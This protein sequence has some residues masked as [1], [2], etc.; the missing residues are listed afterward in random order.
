MLGG[1]RDEFRDGVR[2]G[3]GRVGSSGLSGTEDRNG[4]K[5]SVRVQYYAMK[6]VLGSVVLATFLCHVGLSDA[7]V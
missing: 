4:P 2:E 5:R 1:V 3:L 6:T 7:R